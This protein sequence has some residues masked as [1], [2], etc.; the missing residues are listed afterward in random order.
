MQPRG[1]VSRI[2][3]DEADQIAVGALGF[4]ASDPDRLGRFL[5]MT[6]LGPENLRAAAS[7]PG[8]LGQV[9]GHLAQDESLLLAFA[10]NAGES[11]DRVAAAHQALAGR[12]HERDDA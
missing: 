7:E 11:P 10:A 1:H 3:L 6:G 12:R 8:F 2:S 9:L 4:L 5:A